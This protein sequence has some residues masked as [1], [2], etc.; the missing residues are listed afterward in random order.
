MKLIPAPLL[1]LLALAA[2]ALSPLAAAAPEIVLPNEHDFLKLEDVSIGESE[3]GDP[4]LRGAIIRHRRQRVPP[5]TH[6]Y[7]EALDA[8]EKRV[9]ETVYRLRRTDF[10]GSETQQHFLKF[11]DL[12][13]PRIAK[14]VVIPR[15]GPPSGYEATAED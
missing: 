2:A 7:I 1:A 13:D 3:D 4:V 8:E 10:N 15:T 11:V 5:G 12:S 14:V 6:L 9:S